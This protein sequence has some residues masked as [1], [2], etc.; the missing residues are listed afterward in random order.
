MKQSETQVTS[1]QTSQILVTK[2]FEMFDMSPSDQSPFSG[3]VRMYRQYFDHGEYDEIMK[4][5]D[6]L[7][8][9]KENG[10]GV[11]PNEYQACLYFLEQ[12]KQ[13]KNIRLFEKKQNQQQQNEIK[14]K[15]SSTNDGCFV[16]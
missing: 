16:M 12:A 2:N 15:T 3:F 5:E 11:R 6:F 8:W 14:R 7:L 1:N 13:R 9:L 4:R 10:R